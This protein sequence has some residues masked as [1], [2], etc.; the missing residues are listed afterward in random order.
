MIWNRVIIGFGIWA[1]VVSY[2][3]KEYRIYLLKQ[4]LEIV[5]GELE[6]AELAKA[7]ADRDLAQCWL[8]YGKAL[9]RGDRA[10]QRLLESEVK[11][12]PSTVS[13]SSK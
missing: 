1:F 12:G 7:T 6:A 4:Q 3:L 5:K 8:D 11:R 9:D 13:G 10:A 2:G